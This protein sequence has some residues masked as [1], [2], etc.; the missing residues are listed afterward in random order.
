MNNS[1]RFV[2][3]VTDSSLPGRIECRYPRLSGTRLVTAKS[4]SVGFVDLHGH[5]SNLRVIFSKT[6]LWLRERAYFGRTA[7][8]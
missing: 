3:E 2:R 4:E 1:E 5:S 6:A 7:T 8:Q